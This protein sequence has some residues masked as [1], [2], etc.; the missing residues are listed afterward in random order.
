M[1]LVEKP[2]KIFI[3]MGFTVLYITS[4]DRLMKRIDLVK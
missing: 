3:N 2:S 4:D 1:M